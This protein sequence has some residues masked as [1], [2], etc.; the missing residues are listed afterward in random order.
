MSHDDSHL[1]EAQYVVSMKHYLFTDIHGSWNLLQELLDYASPTQDDL[2]WFGGD[3]IDR[4]PDS[5][6]VVEF[7]RTYG[8]CLVGN[9][10][11]MCLEAHQDPTYA[12]RWLTAGGTQTLDSFGGSVPVEV[13]DYFR[14][15]SDIHQHGSFVQ[16]HAGIK[17][18]VALEQQKRQALRWIRGEFW[19]IPEVPM[20]GKT[21]VFG[22]TPTPCILHDNP[23]V[24][25]FFG[26][27][28][29]GLDVGSTVTGA[30]A[31][32]CLED[33]QVYVVRETGTQRAVYPVPP[34]CLN[35][36]WDGSC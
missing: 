32:L 13:L 17:R 11:Q 22:H 34:I 1:S 23:E 24:E 25:P 21:I 19:G 14:S 29:I 20:P 10:E 18:G 33:L 28:M 8:S 16:V 4:G 7:V 9:H 36:F 3:L 6:Q 12:A 5:A 15:L 2:L 27:G 31:C 26:P 35:G 30:L